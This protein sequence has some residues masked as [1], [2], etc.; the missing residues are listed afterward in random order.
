FPGHVASAVNLTK[1]VG[2]TIVYRGETFTIADPTYI[3]ALVGRK[4]PKYQNST[5]RV[6][7][8]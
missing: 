3:N 2:D 7:A 1:A 8:Y 6:I 5:P 4:M